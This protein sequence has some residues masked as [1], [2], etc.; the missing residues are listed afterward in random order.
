MTSSHMQILM[1]TSIINWPNYI[2]ILAKH[3]SSFCCS[4][5]TGYFSSRPSLKLYE[6]KSNN[7]LQAAKQVE[8]LS[9]ISKA[10][11]PEQKPDLDK[12]RRAMGTMQHHDAVTGTEKQAVAEDYAKRVRSVSI[13]YEKYLILRP[14]LLF[15]HF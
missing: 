6:R 3:C 5:W 2:F 13:E 11:V 10:S 9:G 7:V 8:A 4:Y 14:K 15:M 12:L 1:P